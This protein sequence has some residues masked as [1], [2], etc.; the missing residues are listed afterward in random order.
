VLREPNFEES[1]AVAAMGDPHVVYLRYKL[2][3]TAVETEFHAESLDLETADFSVHVEREGEGIKD[4]FFAVST[5]RADAPAHELRIR[6]EI[7][8]VVR[9][10]KQHRSARAAHDAVRRL[11]EAWELEEGL[12][13]PGKGPRFEF[14]FAGSLI[15]DRGPLPGKE[16]TYAV[17]GEGSF[18]VR[19]AN[20]KVLVERFPEPPAQLELDVK[21]EWR[22]VSDEP[23][24]APFDLELTVSGLFEWDHTTHA[25]D[26]VDA[27]LE[28]NGV[29]LLW[30]YLRSYVAQITGASSLPPLTIYTMKVPQ[31]PPR[32]RPVGTDDS[33]S[34]ADNGAG[35]KRP[36]APKKKRLTTAARRPAPRA[37][38]R[39]R[40]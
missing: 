38:K 14:E 27:W 28:W 39:P 8:A 30:P 33:V 20:Q 1:D 11:L 34:D 19:A 35:T 7:E 37:K 9:F 32:T 24:T 17:S 3:P 16:A 36:A 12:R 15:I 2:T 21:V 6:P 25:R 13:A 18:Y 23:F 31:A 40:R 10:K 4:P 22:H 5:R 26:L 29:Y